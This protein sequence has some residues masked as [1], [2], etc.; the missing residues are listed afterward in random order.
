MIF[1][2]TRSAG[3]LASDIARRYTQALQH[4]LQPLALSPA[5]FL[6]LCEL[7]E[8]DG[9]TQRELSFRL[10]V[11]Q[12]TMANTLARM[13]RDGL[14]ERRPHPDDGRSQLIWLSPRAQALQG[15][16]TRAALEANE[17]LVSGLPAAE[18]ELFLSMLNRVA[19]AMR[20]TQA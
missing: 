8:E 20:T 1:D 10:G 4:R 9:R 19:A 13:L 12:A 14:V 5:Q 15:P 11:E 2:K 7:W 3:V 6:A 18:R 17:A 16:A